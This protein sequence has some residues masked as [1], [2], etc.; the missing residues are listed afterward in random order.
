MDASEHL[1]IAT[2]CAQIGQPGKSLADAQKNVAA[3][4]MRK[5]LVLRLI[6]LGAGC[7]VESDYASA[8]RQCGSPASSPSDVLT[9][10]SGLLR[11]HRSCLLSHAQ[12]RGLAI[13]AFFATLNRGLDTLS[14]EVAEILTGDNLLNF[15]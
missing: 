12:L 13:A 14:F 9:T 15:V 4:S 6:P 5:C 11:R 8:L 7:L 1:A 2:L 3:F 10:R